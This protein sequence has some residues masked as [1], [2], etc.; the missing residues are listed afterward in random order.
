MNTPT[1]GLTDPQIVLQELLDADQGVRDAFA[2]HLAA[3]L[4]ALSRALADSFR[5]LQPVL[6]AGERVN[7]PRTNL[8]IALALGVLDDVVVATKLLTA[9]KLPAAGNVMRQAIEGLAMTLLC[10]T[11]QELVIVARPKQGDLRGRYWEMVMADDRLVQGQRAVEQLGWNAATLGVAPDGVAVLA[12]AQ[13]FFH[14][15]SHCGRFTLASRAALEVPGR[16]H[17][18]GHFDA[19]KLPGY[20][21]HLQ[22]HIGL[23]SVLPPLLDYLL[24]TLPPAHPA[25]A[26]AGPVNPPAPA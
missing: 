12:S 19:A 7:L 3:E 15:F 22:Q 21:I 13:R 11:D 2:Q 5:H 8:A 9:G 23:C 25:P 10:S 6:E 1:D 17:L 26:A 4:D 16:F 14:P 18:G 20:R 24:G